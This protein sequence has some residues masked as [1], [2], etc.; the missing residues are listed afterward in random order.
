[1]E[2]ASTMRDTNP[3][4]RLP[5]DPPYVLPDDAAA[6]S[7]EYIAQAEIR[8]DLLPMP[9]IG[10]PRSAPVV[11]LLQNPGWH[12]QDEHDV[13]DPIYRDLAT[14]SLLCVPFAWC[15]DQR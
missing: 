9:F 10:D 15:I 4:L 8:L 1:S 2:S 6:L 7:A 11:L 3:W 5:A 13:R 14:T 12:P